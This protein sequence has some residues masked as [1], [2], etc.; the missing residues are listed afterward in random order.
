MPGVFI[1]VHN[2]LYLAETCTF[3]FYSQQI[4]FSREADPGTSMYTHQIA[5]SKAYK[6]INCLRNWKVCFLHCLIHGWVEPKT[7]KFIVLL[8]VALHIKGSSFIGWLNGW[9]IS[10]YVL[11]LEKL[12]LQC[13]FINGVNLQIN[14]SFQIVTML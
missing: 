2:R 14:T 4:V 13:E 5:L 10:S 11:C 3:H 6:V 1:S 7:W 12:Q 9:I 8:S